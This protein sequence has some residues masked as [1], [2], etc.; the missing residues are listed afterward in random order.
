MPPILVIHG[1]A[2]AIRDEVRN[3]YLAGL[4]RALTA[5]YALLERGGSALDA[6]L[7]AVTAMEDDPLAFNAGT[8]SSPTRDGT[9]ECDAAVMLSDGSYGAVA[10]VTR[11][12]NPVLVAELVRR[13]TPHVLFAGPGADALVE[14]KIDNRELLTDRSRAALARWRE[15]GSTPTGTATV[16]AVAL[17]AAGLLA[18]ATSTGGVLGK[19]PGRV[20]D[21]PIAGAGT[22][23]DERVAISCTGKGEAF[24]KAVTAK[25]IAMRLEYGLSLP[26][27]VALALDHVERAGGSGGL[28]SLSA[29][30]AIVIGHTT[31][32]MAYGYRRE[33][34]VHIDVS[35][36]PGSLTR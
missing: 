17:D 6:V 21:S 7:R 11:A 4:E 1:G 32:N 15:R 23:A 22:Y 28:I 19:W 35:L 18:A 16:G 3:D 30:G 33:G 26:E 24:L 31:P 25:E 14:H 9:V 2:G 36:A 5:A 29:Q 34:D 8:G 10:G 27:A 13:T 20:G 12:K